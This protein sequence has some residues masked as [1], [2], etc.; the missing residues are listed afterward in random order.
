MHLFYTFLLSMTL[1]SLQ[2]CDEDSKTTSFKCETPSNIR[3][4]MLRLVNQARSK[5]RACGDQF[6]PAVSTL[7]WN[8]K[9]VRAARTHTVDMATN[10]FFDHRGSD[11]SIAESRIQ[12][13]G[14]RWVTAGENLAGAL[15][16]SKEVVN[17]LLRSPTHCTI[18]MN[19][20]FREMGAACQNNADS[21]LILYW[22][23]VFASR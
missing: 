14:Y 10:N 3:N 23:Q 16:T 19:P 17:K 11:N 7:R 15:E 9:L 18:I 20:Q 2:A 5:D 22:T 12:K 1:L 13:A 4:N 6:Y 8:N 21:D